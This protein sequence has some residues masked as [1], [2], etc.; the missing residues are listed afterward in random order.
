MK[1][2]RTASGEQILLKESCDKSA[3]A[4]GTFGFS[5]YVERFAGNEHFSHFS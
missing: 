2:E 1:N 3:T 4:C 5:S